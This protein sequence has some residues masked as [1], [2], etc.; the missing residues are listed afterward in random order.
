MLASEVGSAFALGCR[1]ASPP[2]PD[3]PPVAAPALPSVLFTVDELG[4]NGTL[5][6]AGGLAP[7]GELGNPGPLLDPNPGEAP[8]VGSAVGV[9][10]AWLPLLPPALVNGELTGV[11]PAKEAV[12]M[13]AVSALGLRF[14]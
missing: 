14:G 8:G 5:D 7:M 11:P 6:G 2:A 13:P 10:E 4:L 3:T 9:G 1:D 12:P